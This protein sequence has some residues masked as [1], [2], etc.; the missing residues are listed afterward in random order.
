MKHINPLFLGGALALPS[1]LLGQSAGHY[2]IGVEGVKGGTLPPPGFY[3]R[4]YNY[5]YGA[6]QMNDADGNKVSAPAPQ[7]EMMSSTG[8]ANPPVD[9]SSFGYANAIRPIW[10]TNFKLLGG[11]Y[12]MD[13]LVPIVYQEVKVNGVRQ[14]TSGLGDIFAEPVTFSWHWQKLDLGIGYGLWIPTGDH[15]PGEFDPGL[16]Y[17]SHMAT[18]GATYFF[19]TEKTWSLSALG[20]YEIHTKNSDYDLYPGD[21]LDLEWGL[22]KALNPAFELGISGYWQQQITGD[23]GKGVTSSDKYSRVGVGPEINWNCPKCGLFVAVRY[24]YEV[25][26]ESR[27]QGQMGEITLTK[28][29]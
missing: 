2:P 11:S 22:S 7:P 27:P 15:D 12:G 28:K 24:A 16:G 6:T 26:A 13:V 25:M 18:G 3:V 20:R 29:F 9:F 23:T 10:I 21:T 4:D 17:Y 1:I 5:F 14:D 19:D 8:G